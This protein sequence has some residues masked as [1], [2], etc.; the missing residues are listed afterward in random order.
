MLD[1]REVRNVVL[2]HLPAQT[3]EAA[4]SYLG[5]TLRECQLVLVG[6]TQG[7][8]HDPILSALAEGLVPDLEEIGDAFDA[9]SV[10]QLDD[11]SLRLDG[12]LEVAQTGTLAHLQMQLIQVRLLGRRGGLMVRS[13]PDVTQLLAWIW[14]EL[15][16]QLHGRPPR[17]YHAAT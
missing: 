17:P 7:S 10:I 2:D 6:R 16:D 5:D 1:Q 3:F 8:D 12:E 15:S 13:D 4:V 14:D 11:G 9:S